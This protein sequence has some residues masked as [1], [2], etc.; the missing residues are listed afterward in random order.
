MAQPDATLHD[1][2]SQAVN[3]RAEPSEML[4]EEISDGEDGG[5]AWLLAQE[6]EIGRHVSRVEDA[7][8]RLG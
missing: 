7:L 3:D 8:I 2:P 6:Q 1:V 5:K 4:K